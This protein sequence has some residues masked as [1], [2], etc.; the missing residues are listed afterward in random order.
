MKEY[1]EM[2]DVQPRNRVGETYQV[3]EQN[4][5]ICEDPD[6]KKRGEALDSALLE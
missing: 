2:A 4:H 6:K 1:L 3:W 5:L